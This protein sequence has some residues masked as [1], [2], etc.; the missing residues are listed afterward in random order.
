[1]DPRTERMEAKLID[2]AKQ[3]DAGAIRALYDRHAERVYA[4]VRRIAGDDHQAQDWAQEA[5]L[6][7]F[8]SLDTFR[9]EAQFSTWVHRIAV[10]TA[11]RGQ[12]SMK[13]GFAS[14]DEVPERAAPADHPHLRMDLAA[15]VD[16]LPHRMREIL[17]LHDVEGYT[18]AEIGE[19]LG[20]TSGTCKSQLFKA[21]AKL[22][23]MLEPTA[24]RLEGETIC[25]T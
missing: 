25:S 2:R 18:H 21:R 22:R 5:W 23:E 14:L 9:G 12:R 24:K 7:V 6:K 20:V 4:V 13:G 11:L 15:A 1:M 17:V 19:L 8:R 3:G 10:N 16:R